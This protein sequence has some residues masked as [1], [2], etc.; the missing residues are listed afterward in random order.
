MLTSSGLPS[1]WPVLHSWAAWHT[2]PPPLTGSPQA[3]VSQHAPRSWV[4]GRREAEGAV[5]PGP[6]TLWPLE[7]KQRW[8][9]LKTVHTDLYALYTPTYMY[10]LPRL[11]C[12]PTHCL[13]TS[14]PLT[15]SSLLL[16]LLLLL[17][18]YWFTFCLF[19]KYFLNYISWTALLV[20][21]L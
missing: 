4:P 3:A 6:G 8:H 2:G 19:S 18:F 7:G 15:I 14:T 1:V 16:L 9:R 13:S 21:C 20:K 10:K 17:L 12:V 11:S 5:P